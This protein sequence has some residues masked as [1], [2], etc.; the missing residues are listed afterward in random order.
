MSS[1]PRPCA[2]TIARVAGLFSSLYTRR[3]DVFSQ[4]KLRGM[5]G[6]APVAVTAARKYFLR[7]AEQMEKRL[8][9]NRPYLLG[10][11]FSAAD[12]LVST[13]LAWAHFIGIELSDRLNAYQA[14]VTRRPAYAVATARNFPPSAVAAMR[15]QRGTS[16]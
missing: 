3:F 9:D 14:Q 7:Q 6:E 10:D 1:P 5:Y 16:G 8:S 15:D 2:V 11:E 4:P 12:I 13:C